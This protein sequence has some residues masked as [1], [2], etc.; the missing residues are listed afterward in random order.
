MIRAAALGLTLVVTI[1][2]TG[3]GILVTDEA[4]TD[5]VQA[6]APALLAPF[7]EVEAL[8]PAPT[9]ELASAKA[10]KIAKRAAL[11]I[12]IP[13]CD[14]DPLGRG[15][16]LD[17]HTLVAH[18]DALPG[19]GW[20]RV[21]TANRR[22][23]AVGAGS[24]YRVGELG[25]ARVARAL[26]RRLPLGGR[27]LPPERRWSSSWSAADKLRMLPGVI[28]DSVP[29]APYGAKTKVLRVTSA[30]QEG[31]AG[32]VLDAKGRIVGAVFGVDPADGPR[33]GDPRRRTPRPRSRT[34]ARDARA[35]R[36]TSGRLR[37]DSGSFRM[38]W[39][40]VRSHPEPHERID[41]THP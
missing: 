22:S 37:V 28:V 12:G 27:A 21:T 16:A 38:V 19:G 15:F 17:A 25:V 18:R 14:D 1:L 20:V 23:K 7:P 39:R 26:P 6:S 11:G 9:R 32:P 41:Y 24:A 29:G 40:V 31:D 36:L 2:L 13:A 10:R 3:C 8:A 30:V 33:G 34:H 4:P 35:L 5:V